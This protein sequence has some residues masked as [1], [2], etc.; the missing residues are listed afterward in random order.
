L[1]CLQCNALANEKYCA[2]GMWLGQTISLL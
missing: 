1:V 2:N